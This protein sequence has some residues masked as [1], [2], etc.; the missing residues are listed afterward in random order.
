MLSIEDMK[1]LD[2]AIDSTDSLAELVR[3]HNMLKEEELS[4][5]ARIKEIGEEISR[6][7]KEEKEL[8]IGDCAYSPEYKIRNK[9]VD[10]VL[11]NSS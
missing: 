6:L 1:Q 7:A 5:I 3:I 11:K 4:R 2:S 9:I 10:V 8:R